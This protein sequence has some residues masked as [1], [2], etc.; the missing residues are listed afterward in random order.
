MTEEEIKKLEQAAALRQREAAAKT[1]IANAREQG[2]Q[3]SVREHWAPQMASYRAEQERFREYHE[4]ATRERMDRI[5]R[6]PENYFNYE[7][8]A[9]ADYAKEQEAKRQFDKNNESR[10]RESS[11]KRDAMINQGRGAAE[12]K[13]QAEK[14]DFE[15]KFGNGENYRA[16]QEAA[17]RAEIEKARVAGADAAAENAKAHAETVRMNNESRE[18]IGTEKN[19]AATRVAE[20]RAQA[21]KDETAWEIEAKKAEEMNRREARDAKDL[22][23]RR[24]QMVQQWLQNG[25]RPEK[26]KQMGLKLGWTEQEV[27]QALGVKP[28]G[29]KT[30]TGF[31]NI[32]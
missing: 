29:G 22:E 7:R 4:N 9:A 30:G 28:G 10:H 23:R 18:R 12:V 11:D 31:G 24:G 13:A 27:D 26:I 14:E 15:R 17:R 1:Q 8:K 16:E 6:H 32:G 5:N 3:A 20:I 19:A 2:T 21:S 25:L